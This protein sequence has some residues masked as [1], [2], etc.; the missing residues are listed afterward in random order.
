M[1]RQLIVAGW[2]ALAVLAVLPGCS[3]LS[4]TAEAPVQRIAAPAGKYHQI[5]WLPS[6][7]LVVGY[8]PEELSFTSLLYRLRPD[9]TEFARLEPERDPTCTL[10]TR[11][12][13]PV[14]LPDGRLGFDKQCQFV[15]DGRTSNS[16]QRYLTAYDLE[17][18]TATTLVPPFPNSRFGGFRMTWNPPMT[19]GMI[20]LGVCGG[21]LAWLTPEGLEA[22]S[23]SI[24]DGDQ[25]WRVDGYLTRYTFGQCAERG[26]VASPVW[27]PDGRWLA[28][29][30]SP[31]RIGHATW[32]TQFGVPW[33]I[34][35]MDP[36][37]QRPYPVVKDIKWP[38]AV[39]WSP[40]S[41]WLAFAG[42]MAGHPRSL[43][44]LAPE[45]EALH[46][47]TTRSGIRSLAWSPDG[48]GIMVVRHFPISGDRER[49]ELLLFDVSALVAA[50]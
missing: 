21:S 14:A 20:A 13:A 33:H 43:W 18:G 37:E 36:V 16:D 35:L 28:F 9:G 42:E 44:L 49:G 7:W 17:Q 15:P 11:Y 45:T 50:P 47:V 30:A 12:H 25:G 3:P 19:R 34:Y 2:L 4:R 27:S 1:T 23:F 10:N 38:G 32:R 40:D 6:D 31:Q 5:A 46:R 48:Q 29:V 39:A 41:Q 22:P 24:R 26:R 8:E